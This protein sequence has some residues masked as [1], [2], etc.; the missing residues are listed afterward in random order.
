MDTT[1]THLTSTHLTSTH[2][3]AL[4][5]S[6]RRLS[7]DLLRL[8]KSAQELPLGPVIHRICQGRLRVAAQLILFISRSEAHGQ[9]A[10]L[11]SHRRALIRLLS[12]LQATIETS[13]G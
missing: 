7:Q 11:A 8:S 2:A 12:D 13:S 10:G 5:P 6:I 3:T 1:S 9:R 4:A